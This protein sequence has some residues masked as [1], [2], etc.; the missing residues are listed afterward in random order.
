MRHFLQSQLNSQSGKGVTDLCLDHKL[1]ADVHPAKFSKIEGLE[2]FPDLKLFSASMHQLQSLDGLDAAFQLTEVDLSLNEISDISAL[3]NLRMLRRLRLQHNEIAELKKNWLPLSLV[4]IDLG[5]NQI[6]DISALLHLQNL[7]ILVLNGNRTLLQFPPISENLRQLHLLQCYVQSFQGL[8]GMI[9]LETLSISPGS[10]KGLDLLSVLPNLKTLNI[11]ARRIYAGIHLPP[12]VELHTLRIHKA[13]QVQIV[14]GLEEL[15]MLENLE[16]T[17][18]LL[19]SPPKLARCNALK[20]LQITFSPLK[21][22][23]GIA[24]IETLEKLILI[25]SATPYHQLQ[26]LRDAR[27][28]LQIEI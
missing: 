26:T 5:F 22:L 19:E 13:T 16:I 27:P 3:S 14:E 9:G 7:E 12:M 28:T 20:T 21:N 1:I 8:L 18:S 2:Q 4:E 25:G 17:N 6:A 10:M 15:P 11:N 24:E 23:N